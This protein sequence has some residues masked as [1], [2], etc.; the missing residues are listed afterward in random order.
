MDLC[1]Y[2]ENALE[3]TER[4]LRIAML[5]KEVDGSSKGYRDLVFS[6]R[7]VDHQRGIRE[8]RALESLEICRIL[9][10][11]HE[12]VLEL[13]FAHSE[14]ACQMAQGPK[15]PGDKEDGDITESIEERRC[16]AQ[17][18]LLLCSLYNSIDMATRVLSFRQAHEKKSVTMSLKAGV[19]CS[20]NKLGQC[21]MET[22][23]RYIRAG[24]S[25]VG[26]QIEMMAKHESLETLNLLMA[27]RR[28]VGEREEAIR[29]EMIDR[30]L[31]VLGQGSLEND[32][33]FAKL[34]DETLEDAEDFES[35][36][37]AR[38]SVQFVI[39]KKYVTDMIGLKKEPLLRRYLEGGEEGKEG[40]PGE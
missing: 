32:I 7:Q 18:T 36:E 15:S 14:A 13:S 27:L 24:D 2:L 1:I 28:R 19:V 3:N 6:Q 40:Q 21:V 12:H 26:K 30:V 5:K 25:L 34:I 29:Q 4:A 20:I 9:R 16:K 37:I 35:P 22:L 23:E 8:R 11:F 33:R 10:R 31:A 39:A 38:M 17:I